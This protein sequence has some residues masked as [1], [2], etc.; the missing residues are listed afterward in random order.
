MF[1]NVD[2]ERKSIALLS[3]SSERDALHMIV[4]IVDMKTTAEFN[5]YKSQCSEV[6]APKH[7]GAQQNN[8]SL[9]E[10]SANLAN[11]EPIP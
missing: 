5:M 7:I 6:G 4:G 3:N 10:E 1:S 9:F 11:E 8:I 2:I